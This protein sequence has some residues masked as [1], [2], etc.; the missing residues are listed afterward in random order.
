MNQVQ[1]NLLSVGACLFVL[2]GLF[3]PVKT[4][5]SILNLEHTF[6]FSG[7]YGYIDMANL[8]TRWLIIVV[9]FST[10]IYLYHKSKP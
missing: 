5:N 6:L 10:L 9:T 4:N 7:V 1:K 2:C 3:P 8:I